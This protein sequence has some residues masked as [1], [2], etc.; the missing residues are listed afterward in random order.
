MLC[1]GNISLRNMTDELLR[2]AE[3]CNFVEAI[4]KI[5]HINK[6]ESFID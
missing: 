6:H 4:E 2:Y 3:F 5:Q 1:A